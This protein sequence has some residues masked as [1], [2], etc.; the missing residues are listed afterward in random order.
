[1][2]AI[3]HDRMSLSIK[4][5]WLNED[6]AVYILYSSSKLEAD[7]GCSKNSRIKYMEELEKIGLISLEKQ[8]G[9]PTKIYVHK[10]EVI[11]STGSKN[12]LVQK[13]NQFK[14]STEPVQKMNP[15]YT[16]TNDTNDS[17]INTT[18]TIKVD[19][20]NLKDKFHYD[21]HRCYDGDFP[22]FDSLFKKLVSILSGQETYINVHGSMIDKERAIN[23][24]SSTSE[25]DLDYAA[26]CIRRYKKQITNPSAFYTTVLWDSVGNG[27]SG[28]QNLAKSDWQL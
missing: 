12:E 18:T 16:N 17:L 4:S 15:N 14:K 9:K 19:E 5:G 3:L 27:S 21:Y 25:E 20:D 23:H 22:I 8:Q 13:M 11:N 1:M 10:F 24:L 28:M 2:Y 6:G 26:T 7:M